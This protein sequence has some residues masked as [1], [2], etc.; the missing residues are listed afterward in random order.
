M[1]VAELIAELSRYPGHLPV[2]LNV[3]YEDDEL[4]WWNEPEDA[5]VV[6]FE[7]NHVLIDGK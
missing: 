6:T 1:N 2:M 3:A 5:Y 7:G 4:E